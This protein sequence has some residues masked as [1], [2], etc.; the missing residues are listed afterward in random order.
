MNYEQKYLKYKSKYIQLKNQSS[1]GCWQFRDTPCKLKK[2]TIEDKRILKN[3][4]DTIG[5]DYYEFKPKIKDMSVETI[6]FSDVYTDIK[7]YELD[8]TKEYNYLKLRDDNFVITNHD[9]NL[10]RSYKS[11]KDYFNWLRTWFKNWVYDLYKNRFGGIPR[12]FPNPSENPPKLFIYSKY[13]PENKYEEHER[14]LDLVNR[15]NDEMAKREQ[16]ERNSAI[17]R[18]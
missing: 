18:I 1:G 9:Q 16:A 6:N 13:I 14:E 17:G 15:T 4:L 5:K 12:I 2:L 11:Q 7:N 8:F 3:N 10:L